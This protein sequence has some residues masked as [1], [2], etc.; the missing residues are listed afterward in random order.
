MTADSYIPATS[1][2]RVKQIASHGLVP[3][4]LSNHNPRPRPIAI[5]TG[6][7]NG[8]PHTGADLSIHLLLSDW[9]IL[10]PRPSGYL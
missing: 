7:R 3:S 2:A 5:D 4:L 9:L 1:P 6:I 8:M 10:E